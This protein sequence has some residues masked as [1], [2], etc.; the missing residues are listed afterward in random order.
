MSK[1]KEY[2]KGLRSEES[3]VVSL[4]TSNLMVEDFGKS[5]TKEFEKDPSY[6]RDLIKHRI[7]DNLK[8]L[9]L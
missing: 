6:I 8:N 5:I 2:F 4:I 3:K 1:T 9:K 7:I